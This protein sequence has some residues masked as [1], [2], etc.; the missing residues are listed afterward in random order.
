M[1]LQL[2]KYLT[3]FFCCAQIVNHILALKLPQL[4]LALESI[5]LTASVL[6]VT[7]IFSGQFCFFSLFLL[8]CITYHQVDSLS[9]ALT[10]S[11]L[12]FSFVTSIMTL[13]NLCTCIMLYPFFRSP[14]STPVL[15]MTI[16]SCLLTLLSIRVFLRIRRFKSGMPFLRNKHTAYIGVIISLCCVTLIIYVFYR[17]NQF[18]IL[19]FIFQLIVCLSLIPFIAWWRVHIRKS[20]YTYLKNMELQELQLK[21]QTLT[22]DNDRLSQLVHKD[23]KLLTAMTH[24]VCTLLDEASTLSPDQL[25]S[26]CSAM[27]EDLLRLGQHRQ[28]TLQELSGSLTGQFHTG[29]IMLDSVL[30][31]MFQQAQSKRISLSLETSPDFWTN[32]LSY[33]D[34]EELT[35]L[36]ADLTQNAIIATQNASTKHINLSLSSTSNIPSIQIADSGTPFPP[37]VLNA[38]GQ[39]RCSQHL[40]E[41]GSGIGLMNIWTLK[42]TTKATLLIEEFPSDANYTKCIH[43]IFDQKNRYLIMSPRYDS[44]ITQISRCDV[45][46]M[47]PQD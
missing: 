14:Q 25:E 17:S 40:H 8:V 15:L 38:L 9:L 10:T 39:S 11:L 23:N 33:L 22:A 16:L 34:E 13:C 42:S 5:L 7:L 32:I 19:A 21:I 35:H 30:N 47:S 2:I 46:I 24:S 12:S 3:I 37:V 4:H 20:Y 43:F 18:A 29:H 1:Y 26:H 6:I 45:M 31:M 36:I 27:H 28:A 44:L 41:G